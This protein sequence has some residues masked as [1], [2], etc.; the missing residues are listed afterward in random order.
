MV[1]ARMQNQTLDLRRCQTLASMDCESC[2]IKGAIEAGAEPGA[3]TEIHDC[4]LTDCAQ[5]HVSL[6]TSSLERVTVNGMRRGGRSPLYLWGCTFREVTLAGKLHGLKINMEIGLHHRRDPTLQ[7]AWTK[8]LEGYYSEDAWAL[9][10]REAR[11]TSVPTFEAIP[12]ERVLIDPARQARV[13]RSALNAIDVKSL[14]MAVALDWFVRR[15][16]FESVVLASSS[17]PSR[18][19]GDLD[20]LAKLRDLGIAEPQ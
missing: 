1:R 18:R 13:Q 3:W 6:A 2:T 12:G 14:P 4:R 10:I 16:P 20:K 8:A 11:F 5:I 9:D 17:E 7:M 19:Q 15:S